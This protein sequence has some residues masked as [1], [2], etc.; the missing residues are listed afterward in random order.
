MHK[1]K[2]IIT[3]MKNEAPYILEWVA[4]HLAI[5]FDH[6]VALT[7]DCTDTTNE[8][9]THLQDLGHVTFH[10]NHQGK[11]GIHRTALRIAR[12]LDVVKN[13][14][15]LYVTDAD[16]FLNIHVGDHSVDALIEASGGDNV[17]IIMVPWRI[18]SYNKRTSLSDTPVTEQFTDA[19]PS[20][21]DGG[22]GRRFV[23]SLLRN[24]DVYHRIGLHNPLM[25]EETQNDM[26]WALPGGVQK[27]RSPLGNHVPP[28]FGH[29]IAQINH[30]AVRS[31]QGYLLKKFRG[32]A[33][34]QNHVLDTDYWDRW[35]RGGASDTSIQRYAKEV[36][37]RI[38]AFK[39]DPKLNDL[40]ARG[41]AWHQNTLKA[42]MQDEAY[43]ELYAK[44]AESE[45]IAVARVDRKVRGHPAIP[46]AEEP[47][48]KPA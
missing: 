39:S 41:F 46:P 15:W 34:H 6:I 23:K 28:P 11:G 47:A 2:V 42:L 43:A 30:Y 3:T 35:N 32:R 22:A 25:R 13:A 26:N 37:A 18:F 14:D 45:P 1:S 27:S 16:E 36:N 17:D 19:E 20:F 29:E 5:G 8:I 4:H 44:I 9:L 10:P 21:E 40:H 7:N 31:A 12:R 24:K 38:A 48:V 33:N